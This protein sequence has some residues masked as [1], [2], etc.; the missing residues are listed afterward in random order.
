MKLTPQQ[1]S[2]KE[3]LE[4]WYRD[5]FQ[6]PDNLV[7]ELRPYVEH[8]E[9]TGTRLR[10]PLVYQV[11]GFNA[12]TANAIYEAKQGELDTAMREG[13]YAK[14]LWI[15]ERPYRVDMLAS[16]WDTHR[17]REFLREWL[18]EIYQDSE[19][20]YQSRTLFLRLFRA[21][22]L[23]GCVL[24]DSGEMIKLDEFEIPEV[25]KQ[26]EITIYRGTR[27]TEPKSKLGL[28]WTTDYAQAEWFARRYGATDGVIWTGTI[29]PEKVLA[30][31][32]GRGESEIVAHT[33]HFTNPPL[34]PVSAAF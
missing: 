21:A 17:D 18:P 34:P 24:A 11:F 12:W 26:P 9:V 20:P 25:L 15:Y 23:P 3:Y 28:S 16:L 31:I 5:G 6:D 27:N 29:K 2:Q 4:Q 30:Y 19:Y 1:E 32:Q 22:K 13:N 10:H 7:S 8:D 14:A 33:R